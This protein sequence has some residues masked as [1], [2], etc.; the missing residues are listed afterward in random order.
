MLHLMTLLQDNMSSNVNTIGVKFD[1]KPWEHLRSIPVDREG[2]YTYSLRPRTKNGQN[3]LMCE[4]TMKDN[5]K[6]LQVLKTGAQQNSLE[7]HLNDVR[8]LRD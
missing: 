3:K 6:V 2:V 8:P 4:I 5:V 7:F 1:S